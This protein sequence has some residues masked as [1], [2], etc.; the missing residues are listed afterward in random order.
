[1]ADHISDCKKCPDNTKAKYCS[2]S[3]HAPAAP[4]SSLPPTEQI[5]EQAKQQPNM[6]SGYSSTRTIASGKSVAPVCKGRIDRFADCLTTDQHDEFDTVLSRA[7]YASGAPLSLTENVYWKNAMKKIRPAY[8][9]P[10]RYKLTNTLLKAEYD[11]VRLAAN[12]EIGAAPSLALMCDGWTNIRNE[13]IINF[14][15]TTPKPVFYKSIST[16]TTSHTGEFM[17]TTMLE[18]ISEIGS[19]KFIGIVTDNAANMKNA[20]TRIQEEHPHLVCYGCG[21]HGIQLLLGDVCRLQ[22]AADIL[23]RFVSIRHYQYHDQ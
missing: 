12:E 23:Q 14:V 22:S 17:A 11:R 19:D 21:A 5:T 3:S 18:V 9:L 4:P 10:S 2:N 8:S 13:S 6:S 7:I 1:M 16:G 15:I 20:W